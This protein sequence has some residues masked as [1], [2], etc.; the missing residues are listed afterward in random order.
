MSA[1]HSPSQIAHFE[2]RGWVLWDETTLQGCAG[3]YPGLDLGPWRAAAD[4]AG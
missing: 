2:Q 3:R 1:R 4:L